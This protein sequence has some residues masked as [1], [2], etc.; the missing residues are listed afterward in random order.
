MGNFNVLGKML[1]DM[2]LD[3]LNS[4][5]DKEAWG[6]ALRLTQSLDLIDINFPHNAQYFLLLAEIYLANKLPLKAYD[7]LKCEFTLQIDSFFFFFL[8]ILIHNNVLW[9]IVDN[10]YKNIYI[11]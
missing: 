6:L 3:I 4:L 2:G 11:S 7:L 1:F 8:E 10:K 5:M 9:K